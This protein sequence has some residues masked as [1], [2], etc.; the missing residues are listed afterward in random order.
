[1]DII[2]FFKLMVDRGA[3][4]IFF[5]VGAPPNMKVEGE[6]FQLAKRLYNPT[7]AR[8]SAFNHERCATKRV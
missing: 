7:N 3:S 4:D 1:M 8:N 6:T 2:P 5:S